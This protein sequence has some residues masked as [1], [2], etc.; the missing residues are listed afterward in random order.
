MIGFCTVRSVDGQ[1]LALGEGKLCGICQKNTSQGG[2]LQSQSYNASM[3]M[4][5]PSYLHH[6]PT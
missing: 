3:L 4:M 1:K 2:L 6:D 5:E